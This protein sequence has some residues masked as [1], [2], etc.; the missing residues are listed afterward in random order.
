MALNTG[1]TYFYDTKFAE[2]LN[3]DNEDAEHLADLRSERSR[4]TEVTLSP[5]A[6]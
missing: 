3:V 5:V 4:F 2:L 6:Y 1:E